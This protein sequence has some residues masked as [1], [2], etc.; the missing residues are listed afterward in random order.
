MSDAITAIRDAASSPMQTA[1]W[2]E[3]ATITCCPGCRA[4]TQPGSDLWRC[5]APDCVYAQTGF[6]VVLGQPALVDFDCSI[7]RR[8]DYERGSGSVLRRDNSGRSLR[9]RVR[10]AMEGRNRVANRMCQTMLRLVRERSR[11]PLLL[12]VGGGA[13][14]EGVDA[15][16][17]D[18]QVH[19]GYRR[20]CLGQHSA[21][22]RWTRLAVS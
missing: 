7:F 3:L 8:A 19:R 2:E 10:R 15:L 4:R 9:T 5:T 17:A 14:G 22:G 1:E 21:G 16:Y 11:Q 6:P 13:I 20:V 12:V 18:P